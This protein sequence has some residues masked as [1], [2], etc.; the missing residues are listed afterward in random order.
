MRLKLQKKLAAE[1]L[2][3]S[4]S[5]IKFDAESLSQIKD[6]ITRNDIRALIGKK[7]ISKKDINE[8]SRSRARKNI[9]QKRKGRRKGK[10]SRK[11]TKNSRIPRKTEWI[12]KI[13]VQRDF[14]KVLK[15]NG[16]IDSKTYKSIYLKSKGGFF[17]SRRH[18]RMFMEEHGLIKDGKK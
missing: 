10:G 1:I 4:E 7:I 3:V 15:Q 14:L 6:A 8:Q 12:R 13:R 18:V 17:R 9:I 16:I 2:K 11:G 5:K